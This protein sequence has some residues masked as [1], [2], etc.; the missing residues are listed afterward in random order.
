[1]N[2]SN[3]KKYHKI[4]Y[5]HKNRNFFMNKTFSKSTIK[6]AKQTYATLSSSSVVPYLLKR[7]TQVTFGHSSK[8]RYDQS[9]IFEMTSRPKVVPPTPLLEIPSSSPGTSGR[10]VKWAIV[11]V[12]A[13]ILGYWTLRQFG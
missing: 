9:S 4:Q 12:V 8:D 5:E 7:R 11:G 10:F 2:N 6:T 3:K 13:S 1:M